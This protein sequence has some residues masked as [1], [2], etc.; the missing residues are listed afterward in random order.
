MKNKTTYNKKNI[1]TVSRY[2]LTKSASVFEPV[3]IG[4]SSDAKNFI[5]QFYH[6]DIGIY[7]SFFIVLLSRSGHTEG[8]AKISQGGTAGTVVD[9]KIIAKY[10]IDSLASSVVLAH[11]HPSGN[12]T[13]SQ[14]DKNI[15]EKVVNALKLFDIQ[16]LD[17]VILT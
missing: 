4:S 14:A 3:K 12:T 13:P 9:V 7:E 11:N 10:A 1:S 16:V 8:F 17:H 5:K 2:G 15:T 6:E